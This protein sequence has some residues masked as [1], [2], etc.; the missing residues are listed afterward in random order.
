MG[1][2]GSPPST[3][4]PGTPPGNVKKPSMEKI[5]ARMVECRRSL[6][7]NFS[8]MG[9]WEIPN[10]FTAMAKYIGITTIHEINLTRNL[11]EVLPI[12]M[13]ETK[14]MNVLILKNN[15]FR[16]IPRITFTFTKLQVLDA[17]DN[18]MKDIDMSLSTLTNMR[19]IDIS[20]NLLTGS[21]PCFWSN[22]P[23]L[24]NL[25][26]SKNKVTAIPASIELAKS[27]MKLNVSENEIT[28]LPATMGKLSEL[29]ELDI[30]INKI[31]A[32]P[33]TVGHLK[34]LQRLECLGFFLIHGIPSNAISRRATRI[35]GK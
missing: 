4:E 9:M 3:G 26:I 30:H 6:K 13:G 21:L 27:L 15:R 14:H 18:F 20:H 24:I 12:D 25:N 1:K 17:S 23:N 7:L 34:N 5:K 29:V 33:S 35:Q 31:T 16:E 19:E 8:N 32:L 10:K 2:P 22:M 11:F 28:S